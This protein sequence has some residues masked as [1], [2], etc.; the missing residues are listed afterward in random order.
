MSSDDVFISKLRSLVEA[1]LANSA[2]SVDT[3]CREMGGVPQRDSC[4][5]NLKW[6]A[7]LGHI[8]K[9]MKVVSVF[10]PYREEPVFQAILRQ[11]RY[12]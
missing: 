10:R 9:D 5:H 1:K 11:Y 4:L 3:I 8:Y 7:D 12:P 6:A 2:F